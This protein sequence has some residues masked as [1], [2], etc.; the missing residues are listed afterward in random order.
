MINFNDYP[1]L[2]FEHV[3]V[4][5][6][7]KLFQSRNTGKCYIFLRMEYVGCEYK[8][9][10]LDGNSKFVYFDNYSVFNDFRPL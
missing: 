2:C 3:N 5:F 4:T 1:Q 9:S 7:G 6:G 8:Y 10:F